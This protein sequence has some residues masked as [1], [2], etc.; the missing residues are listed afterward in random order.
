MTQ[1]R[2]MFFESQPEQAAPLS[3]HDDRCHD[4][5]SHSALALR[6]LQPLLKLSLLSLRPSLKKPA[7]M[8]EK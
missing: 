4:I 1:E 6:L 2:I 5:V 7:T 3:R 8:A